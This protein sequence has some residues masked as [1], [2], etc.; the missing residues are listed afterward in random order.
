MQVR[1]EIVD[2][3]VP[4]ADAQAQAAGRALAEKPAHGP[5]TVSVS[6][7]VCSMMCM[8]GRCWDLCW[9]DAPHGTALRN[10]SARRGYL[11]ALQHCDCSMI[12]V[13]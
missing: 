6:L 9:H 4:K 1:F 10:L 2:S 7:Q 3:R 13:M 12:M 5:Y 11:Q 8:T